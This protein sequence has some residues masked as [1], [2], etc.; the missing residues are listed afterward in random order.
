MRLFDS[1]H[2]PIDHRMYE[3]QTASDHH[4]APQRFAVSNTTLVVDPL[5]GGPGVWDISIAYDAS[6]VMF[7][8]R[9][10]HRTEQGLS[11]AGVVGLATRNQLG[12]SSMSVGGWKQIPI[13]SDY[14]VYT[15]PAGAINLS[16]K[17]FTASAEAI[18]LTDA[19]IY[20]TVP[21]TTRVFRTYWTNYGVAQYTL[22]A[23]GEIAIVG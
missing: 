14:A 2:H 6:M 23:Y 15:K 20:E 22:N 1:L 19:W 16:H 7:R 21:G 11:R 5:P 17:V 12:A 13:A 10:P 4:I 8:F 3:E 18:C 9:G